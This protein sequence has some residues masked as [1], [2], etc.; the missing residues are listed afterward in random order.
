MGRGDQLYKLINTFS[1]GY[2]ASRRSP[3]TLSPYADLFHGV[4]VTYRLSAIG[5]CEALL[6][7][8]E[9]LGR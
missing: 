1:G 9:H 7:V 8:L 5:L 6:N 3:Y 2:G 4:G